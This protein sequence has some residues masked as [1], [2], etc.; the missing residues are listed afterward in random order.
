MMTPTDCEG[1]DPVLRSVGE[2]AI[3]GVGPMSAGDASRQDDALSNYSTS[4]EG[5]VVREHNLRY[6]PV[7][8]L[9]AG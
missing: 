7:G 9:A 4:V 2:P 3:L 8:S 1:E 6:L 5:S